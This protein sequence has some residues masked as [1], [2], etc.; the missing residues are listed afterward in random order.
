M[1][2]SDK[3]EILNKTDFVKLPDTGPDA[4]P[5]MVA[6]CNH[7]L[8][9][10]HCISDWYIWVV[11]LLE[12]PHPSHI[13]EGG[14]PDKEDGLEEVGLLEGVLFGPEFVDVLHLLHFSEFPSSHP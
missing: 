1:A 9:F 3:N 4:A 6:L 5:Y 10:N 2:K 14:H 12:V 13:Y 11:F 8:I 7:L